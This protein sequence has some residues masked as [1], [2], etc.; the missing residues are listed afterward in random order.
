MR[1]DGL[2]RISIV[3][4]A[5]SDAR[6]AARC[7]EMPAAN[8]ASVADVAD[9]DHDVWSIRKVLTESGAALRANR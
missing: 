7:G 3:T 5:R 6:S 1:Q 2:D 8:S 9:A 4:P